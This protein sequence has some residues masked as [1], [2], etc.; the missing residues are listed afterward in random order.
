MKLT[1]AVKDKP[2]QKSLAGWTWFFPWSQHKAPKYKKAAEGVNLVSQ[3]GAWFLISSHWK[4][5]YDI[6]HSVRHGRYMV[7]QMRGCMLENV[8]RRKAILTTKSYGW[9]VLEQKQ[10]R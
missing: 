2:V 3:N 9:T 5:P 10:R 6:L 7:C 8:A 4:K 1:K